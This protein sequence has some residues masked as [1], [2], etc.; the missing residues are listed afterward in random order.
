MKFILIVFLNLLLISNVFGETKT[1]ITSQC[2]EGN[3]IDGK[4]KKVFNNRTVYEG[5]F[6]DA[7]Y[8]GKGKI[9]FKSGTVAEGEFNN[10]FFEYGKI[11]YANGNI[12][13][14]GYQKG[15]KHGQGRYTFANGNIYEGEYKENKAHGQG[16]Y[17]WA[18]G[19]AYEGGYKEGNK[20]GKGKYT[21]ADGTVKSGE[22]ENDKQVTFANIDPKK[23]WEGAINCYRFTDNPNKKEMK[24][25]VA[26]LAQRVENYKKYKYDAESIITKSIMIVEY[27]GCT[28]DLFK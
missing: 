26:A 19:E 11:T 5:K 15:K 17:T 4:G 12:Y 14:G 22:W 13:E 1:K 6:K 28:K 9:T 25:N 2:T 8:H 20:H 7:K 18:D 10:S 16:K 24:T 23:Y 3:C 27:L 21:W